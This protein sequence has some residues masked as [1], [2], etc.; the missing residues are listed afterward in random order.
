M[1]YNIDMNYIIYRFFSVICVT[2]L[3]QILHIF[4]DKFNILECIVAN[5]SRMHGKYSRVFD[6][7]I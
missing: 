3:F 5:K 1:N 6:T 4:V 7:K 2:V